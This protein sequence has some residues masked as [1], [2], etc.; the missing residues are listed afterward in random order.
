MGAQ[1]EVQRKALLANVTFVRLLACMHQLVPFELRVIKELLTTPLMRAPVQPFAVRDEVLPVGHLVIEDL[2]AVFNLA[3]KLL[4]L[5]SFK[6]N[7]VEVRF[8]IH[9][10]LEHLMQNI[11]RQGLFIANYCCLI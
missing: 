5:V 2:G 6:G 11:W 10:L 7:L 4:P 1:V 9:A 3:H 8:L